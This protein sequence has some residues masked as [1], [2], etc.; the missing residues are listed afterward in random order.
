MADAKITALANNN[1]V[2]DTDLVVIVDDVSGTP[3]SEKRTVAEIGDH[4]VNSTRVQTAGALMDS[5]CADVADVKA[6]NFLSGSGAPA[7]TPTYE[8]QTYTDTTAD[9]T[10][11]ATGTASSADWKVVAAGT[12]GTPGKGSLLVGDGTDSFD[13]VTAGTND[14]F[15]VYDS[16]QSKGVKAVDLDSGI[17]FIIDGGGSAISTGIKGD[18]EVPF[19]CT[20]EQVTMLAD[21]S[22]SVVVDIWKDTYANYAPTDADSITASAVPTISAATK[23]QDATLTGWTTALS[24]GDILRYNVDSASTVERVTISLRVRR[25]F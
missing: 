11:I 20:I 21:Q 14:Q 16:A 24:Q 15:I 10:Y 17:N 4:I 1:T 23:S 3:T 19:D 13:E 2:D 18:I 9:L 8:G 5:E 22:G 7:T 25:N 6:L 12:A